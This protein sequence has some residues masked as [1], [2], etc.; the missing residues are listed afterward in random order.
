[1]SLF[2]RNLVLIPILF[3]AAALGLARDAGAQIPITITKPGPSVAGTITLEL[4]GGVPPIPNCTGIE[5]CPGAGAHVI[6]ATAPVAVG[7][8]TTPPALSTALAAALTAAGAPTTAGP[9]G[10]TITPPPGVTHCCVNASAEDGA[11]GHSMV[12]PCIVNNIADGVALNGAAAPTGGFTFSKDLQP[13][14]ALPTWGVLALVVLLAVSGG[15][16]VVT[17][18]RP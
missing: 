15:A 13:V 3:M 2:S 8:G 5:A 7:P 14:P 4:H 18:M 6:T 12:V 1:M 11:S 17:R 16:F 9:N 10:I